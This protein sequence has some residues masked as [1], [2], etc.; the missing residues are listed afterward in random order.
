M[1][2]IN[3]GRAGTQAGLAVNE[4]PHLLVGLVW[5]NL[6]WSCVCYGLPT[7]RLMVGAMHRSSLSMVAL[8]GCRP[9]YSCAGS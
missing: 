8:L 9:S 4:C 5:T 1:Q 7:I 2:V 3:A 6:I